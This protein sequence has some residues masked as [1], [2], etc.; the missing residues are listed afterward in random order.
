MKKEP[1]LT[2]AL[3]IPD[4]KMV[5]ID[6]VDPGLECNCVCP[7]CHKRLIAKNKSND[8]INGRQHHF[9]HE[10]FFSE[11]NRKGC[12]GYYMSAVHR[13]AEQIIEE[14]KQIMLPPYKNVIDAVKIYFVDVEIEKRNDRSDIQPDIVGITENGKRFHIEIPI[15]I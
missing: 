7:K 8:I 3:H 10:Q 9:A 13:L 2:W 5:H 11:D 12:K 1:E 4:D 14:K 6:S 15:F